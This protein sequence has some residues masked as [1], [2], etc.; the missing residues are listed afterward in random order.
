M[1]V[2]VNKVIVEAIHSKRRLAFAYNG[3]KRLV[4]P[5]CYGT[6][7]KGTALLRAHQIEGGLQ[8]EPLFDVAKIRD[9]VL[10]EQHFTRP[11]PNYKKNDS[12]MSHI[13]AQL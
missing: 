10:L 11:G 9:L 13:F 2:V 5:Q 7:T 8:R 1:T 3:T 6:G 4:E 12:A